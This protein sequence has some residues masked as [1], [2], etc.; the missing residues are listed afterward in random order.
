MADYSPYLG[1]HT[2]SAAGTIIDSTDCSA[3]SYGLSVKVLFG[4]TQS[5]IRHAEAAVVNSGTASLETALLG[6]PQVVGYIMGSR[7]TYWV[8]KQI[9]KIRYISLG[10]LVADRFVFKEFI[11]DECTADN[12]IAETRTLIEDNEYR[13]EMLR[14]YAGIRNALGGSG[15]SR[16]V[17]KAMT[18]LLKEN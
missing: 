7:L 12:I 9:V 11:Q 3:E 2:D 18:D 16:A 10:N 15:A 8:A 5:I 6:T 17:A 1:G 4:E 13:A 14:G